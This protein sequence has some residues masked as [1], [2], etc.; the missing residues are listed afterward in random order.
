MFNKLSDLIQASSHV[1]QNLV[2]YDDYQGLLKELLRLRNTKTKF[3]LQ[4]EEDSQ[5][6]VRINISLQKR[7]DSLKETMA[8]LEKELDY[9]KEQYTNYKELYETE[10]ERFSVLT[11]RFSEKETELVRTKN[12]RDHAEMAFIQ[13]QKE[14]EGKIA[15]YDELILAQLESNKKA[16]RR[17]ERSKFLL[18]YNKDLL[19]RIQSQ[20]VGSSDIKL[21]EKDFK[22]FD[23]HLSD[24]EME[25]K[26]TSRNK[27]DS[28]SSEKTELIH[29]TMNRKNDT[30]ATIDKKG[31]VYTTKISEK[32]LK[33][34]F[35][36][37]YTEAMSACCFS[38]KSD[39]LILTDKTANLY[40]YNL[41]KK[42]KK[43][44]KTS[45]PVK[46]FDC[47]TEDRVFC[48]AEDSSIELYDI[49]KMSSAGTNTALTNC[50]IISLS[51]DPL[52]TLYSC[53]MGGKNGQLYFYD[54]KSNQI[55]Q[56]IKAA[57]LP[58]V[59]YLS[60]VNS[61]TVAA[62]CTSK[63]L[64]LI[65]VRTSRVYKTVDL[66]FMGLSSN[67]GANIAVGNNKVISSTDSGSVYSI[68]IYNE[69][70]VEQCLNIGSSALHYL[71]YDTQQDRIT[72]IDKWGETTLLASDLK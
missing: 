45:K 15:Q 13:K 69:P 63:E 67:K 10:A 48:I 71:F 17:L 49:V 37:S 50:D 52:Q 35:L 38:Y 65:D 14:I 26:I 22:A 51:Y 31:D 34:S 64:H 24:F 47:T 55:E 53:V 57:S 42:V 11:I 3:Q 70:L 56:Q 33:S 12:E 23:D 58:C 43:A 25:Y 39:Y 62:G 36:V 1:Q 4:K 27:L 9:Y 54:I 41:A 46:L 59:D 6:L 68:D 66:A 30:L 8:E 72:V 5:S 19:G 21:T 18:R 20:K 16:D 29:A 28:G 7:N 61:Y 2:E 40:H 32:S 44:G 60:I